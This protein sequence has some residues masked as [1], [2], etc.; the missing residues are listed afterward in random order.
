MDVPPLRSSARPDRPGAVPTA[1]GGSRA[2]LLA[3]HPS[4]ALAGSVALRRRR[5]NRRA[6]YDD[7]NVHR[8]GRLSRLDP[9]AGYAGAGL[10]ARVAGNGDRAWPGASARTLRAYTYRKPGD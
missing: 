4:G 3:L 7:P 6:G 5:I 1:D 10:L 9:C 2:V 8:P